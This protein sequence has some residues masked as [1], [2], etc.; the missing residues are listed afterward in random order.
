MPEQKKQEQREW[1]DRIMKK[2]QQAEED[3]EAG[4]TEDA[5]ESLQKLRA[6]YGL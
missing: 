5:M 3:I 2:C 1:L 4:R 6:K